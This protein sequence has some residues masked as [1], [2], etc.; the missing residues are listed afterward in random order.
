MKALSSSFEV[1][2][3]CVVA[4]S[5]KFVFEKAPPSK[6]SVEPKASKFDGSN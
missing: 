4:K 6:E 1:G 5:L 2:E 3:T